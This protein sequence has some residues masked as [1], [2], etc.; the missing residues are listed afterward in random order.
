[1]MIS[2]RT[3]VK[4]YIPTSSPSGG[5]LL[6]TID[7]AS[8]FNMESTNSSDPPPFSDPPA[9]SAMEGK[10]IFIAANCFVPLT[11][12]DMAVAVN[13]I[14]K[15]PHFH[16]LN[17][18]SEQEELKHAPED[19]DHIWVSAIYNLPEHRALYVLEVLP[20]IPYFKTLTPIDEETAT[21][22]SLELK[23]HPR[24]NKDNDSATCC[25]VIIPG[26]CNGETIEV[27]EE[28]EEEVQV[29]EE[30][31]E[32]IPRVEEEANKDA[33]PKESGLSF[34]ERL[35]NPAREEGWPAAETQAPA[36][37]QT[38]PVHERSP[39]PDWRLPSPVPAP[40]R[41]PR[42][43]RPFYSSLRSRNISTSAPAGIKTYTGNILGPWRQFLGRGDSASFSRIPTQ[44]TFS[45]LS[46]ISSREFDR[47]GAKDFYTNICGMVLFITP[48]QITRTQPHWK[49]VLCSTLPRK[50]IAATSFSFSLHA[51][52]LNSV[53]GWRD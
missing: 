3:R 26:D 13:S 52:L 5:I 39:S 53:P 37:P 38:D 44:E 49:V 41:A 29:K 50:R 8:P 7:L 27:K 19:D 23:H 10:H 1:M 2:I 42:A 32:A 6:L 43:R 40:A 31:A 22:K 14:K 25:P 51:Q 18:L 28:D 21:D 36:P 47:E 24:F 30:E 33:Q 46:S 9:P 45:Q 34:I 20:A 15:L 48:L 4:A 16:Q 11:D 12:Q 35:Q 17:R